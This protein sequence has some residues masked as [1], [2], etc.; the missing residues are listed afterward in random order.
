MTDLPLLTATSLAYAYGRRM[1]CLDVDLEIWPGEVVAIVGESGSG[2]STL[3]GCLSGRLRPDRGLNCATS[4]A[5]KTKLKQ[6][7]TLPKR[8]TNSAWFSRLG[9]TNNASKVSILADSWL[10]STKVRLMRVS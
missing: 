2:K 5:S 10:G 8:H 7:K 1:A 4:K 9:C 6:A 3:L